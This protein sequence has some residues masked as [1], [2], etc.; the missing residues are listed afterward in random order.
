MDKS[1]A[2]QISEARYHPE[3]YIESAWQTPATEG[4]T[5]HLL[6]VTWLEQGGSGQRNYDLEDGLTRRAAFPYEF[7]AGRTYQ[8]IVTPYTADELLPAS[9]PYP[10]DNPL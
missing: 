3:G 8:L 5:G 9:K 6:T 10:I 1:T 4:L 7:R 2:T